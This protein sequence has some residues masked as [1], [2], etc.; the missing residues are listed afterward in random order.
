MQQ[1]QLAKKIADMQQE[2]VIVFEDEDIILTNKAFNR[3]FGVSSTE[4]YKSSFGAF[5]NNFVPHPSYFNAQK[6]EEGETWFEA[7][8]KLDEIDR[9]VSILSSAHEPCAFSVTL[10]ESLENLKIVTFTDITQSL[11][12]RIM[13]ENN[14]SVDRKTGAYTKQ[15]F[16]QI[17]QSFEEAAVFNEK[18]IG[19]AMITLND[20]I[21]SDSAKEFVDMLKKHTRQDDML[22]KWSK[23]KFLMAY[24]VDNE[25]RIQQVKNK[26]HSI[27]SNKEINP[28]AFE[29]TNTHQTNEEKIS[30]LLEKLY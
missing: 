8:L 22:I 12:K 13:I 3:F 11:I 21:E 16:L 6:I 10:D 4:E 18:I 29:L 28:Y 20:E 24:L 7:I 2:F 14:A 25:E 27:L 23:E 17:K 30:M 9:V 26:L 1:L 19:L 5:I 15:Y